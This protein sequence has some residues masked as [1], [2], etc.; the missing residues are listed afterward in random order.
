M[1]ASRLSIGLRRA[2]VALALVVLL[3]GVITPAA[4]APHPSQTPRTHQVAS[5]AELLYHARFWA[6]S[7]RP[8]NPRGRWD[9]Y[10]EDSS[11]LVSAAWELDT[12]GLTTETLLSVSTRIRKDQLLPGDILDNPD[13]GGDLAFA[14]VVIF[15]GWS[16]AAHTRYNGF[17][18]SPFYGGAH[19]TTDIT[20]PYSPGYFHDERDYIPLRLKGLPD[21]LPQATTAVVQSHQVALPTGMYVGGIAAGP[22]GNLWFTGAAKEG[23]SFASV[24]GRVAADGSIT[25]FP[26][27]VTSGPA[28]LGSPAYIT[29]GP[30]GLW[31]DEANSDGI[32][33]I[34]T[35][36]VA[37]ADAFHCQATNN[38]C[39]VGAI[40]TDA[41]GTLW[42]E[43][44]DGGYFV[45]KASSNGNVTEYF[46]PFPGGSYP[47]PYYLPVDVAIAADGHVWMPYA[48]LAEIISI[49][50]KGQLTEYPMPWQ[51]S[52]P[53]A[54]AIG[55]D[56]AV[57]CT[58]PGANMIVR[59]DASG[60][61]A[62]FDMPTQDANPT[63][64]ALGPDGSLWF[65]EG[66][67][68][69]GTGRIGRI[70]PDGTITEYPG[71]V[72]AHQYYGALALGHDGVLWLAERGALYRLTV[73]T[74]PASS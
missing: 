40:A 26:P 44:I 4:A 12:P 69:G 65:F 71:P 59:I 50:S 47:Q 27:A 16:D 55:A 74:V 30:G 63:S 60:Q 62:S 15:A 38:S 28:G 18:E 57:W 72:V 46:L 43:G 54:A 56:G 42:F 22:D 5:R 29:Q 21:A 11:G 1:T 53:M 32:G 2:I 66:G 58:D 68:F 6:N 33:H 52:T 10:R 41:H 20:Y 7:H 14:H 35:S 39:G 17:E 25:V 9:G 34:T 70:A 24:I 36:G 64:L 45:G 23:R 8:Y 37:T 48:G 67:V 51:G 61:I 13:G 49:T 31:Y 3:A 73:Q 19:Y